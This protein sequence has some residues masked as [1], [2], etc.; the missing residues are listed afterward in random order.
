[1]L[2]PSFALASVQSTTSYSAVDEETPREEKIVLIKE[3]P[4]IPPLMEK[5]AECESGNRQFYP[6]G[7]IVKGLMTPAH[8]GEDIGKFQI[9][10]KYHLARAEA[11]GLDLWNE[12]DNEI[13]AM[14]LFEE[15]GTGPWSSSKGCW[16]K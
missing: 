9:N 13:Y 2:L 11:L 10:T 15:Q 3:R 12:V 7:S 16:S 4:T 8:L 14:M 6:D 1:V 5:I